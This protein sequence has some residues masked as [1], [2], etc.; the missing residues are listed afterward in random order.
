MKTNTRITFLLFA[1]LLALAPLAGSLQ[2]AKLDVR[3]E[4]LAE[5][6]K[7]LKVTDRSVVDQAVALIRKGE[8]TA[9]LAQ[10]ST[11]NRA[12]P[13]NSSLRILTAYALLQVGNLV[14]AFEEAKKAE[15][16]PNGNSYKCWFL[17]K[18]AVLA[19][20]R[21]VCKRE[22]KHVKTVGDM[23]AEVRALEKDL[24]KN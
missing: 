11:L 20:D 19:G 12:N 15:S 10:L 2:C 22:L 8:N 23:A 3:M 7:L 9:A 24:R 1:G 5:S 16:A 14:G 17:A 13:K 18:V 4:R 6:L 21:K